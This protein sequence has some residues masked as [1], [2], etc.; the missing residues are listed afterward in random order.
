MRTLRAKLWPA[1]QLTAAQQRSPLGTARA[2]VRRVRKAVPHRGRSAPAR[3]AARDP[4]QAVQVRRMSAPVQ[5][6]AGPGSARCCAARRSQVR[7]STLWQKECPPGSP[8]GAR[9]H[10]HAEAGPDGATQSV[11]GVGAATSGKLSWEA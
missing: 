1:E 11:P 8:A 7:V 9:G 2:S 3:E 5:L 10:P 6:P 4:A